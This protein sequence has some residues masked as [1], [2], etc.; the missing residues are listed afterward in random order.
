MIEKLTP[1]I[2]AAV[3]LATIAAFCGLIALAAGLI[4]GNV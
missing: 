4:A 1:A 2:E 3:D